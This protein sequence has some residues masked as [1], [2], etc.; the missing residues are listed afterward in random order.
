[1]TLNRTPEQSKAVPRIN[2]ERCSGCGRCVTACRQRIITL[3]T[4]KHRKHALIT[5][6]RL[7][8]G[9]G[10]CIEACPIDAL[11]ISTL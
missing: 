1:M 7:C 9:C 6:P 2:A 3:E 5:D 11:T 8:T 4:I 10:A